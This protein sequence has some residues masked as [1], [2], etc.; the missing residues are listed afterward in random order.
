MGLGAGLVFAPCTAAV[1]IH[2]RRRR[3]LAVGMSLTGGSVGAIVFP[4]GRRIF[5]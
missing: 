3:S 2:F 5:F 1:G 4:I